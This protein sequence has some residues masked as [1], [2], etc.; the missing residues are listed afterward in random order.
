M[1]VCQMNPP[2]NMDYNQFFV[3]SAFQSLFSELQQEEKDDDV[4][5]N[6]PD[7]RTVSTNAPI[8]VFDNTSFLNFKTFS[9]FEKAKKEQVKN[10]LGENKIQKTRKTI[11]LKKNVDIYLKENVEARTISKFK[12]MI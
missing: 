9:P 5:T 10:F 7:S 11:N 12:Y 2:Q 6:A 4:S 3:K 1:S 8:N